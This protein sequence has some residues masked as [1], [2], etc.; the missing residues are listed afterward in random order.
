M[1]GPEHYAE[2]ER[3]L[4]LEQVFCAQYPKPWPPFAISPSRSAVLAMRGLGL[5]PNACQTAPCD[6]VSAR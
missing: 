2:V 5:A 1:T 3:L 6:S 4:A